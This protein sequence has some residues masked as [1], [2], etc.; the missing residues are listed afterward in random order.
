[1]GGGGGSNGLPAA[2]GET[3]GA[4]GIVVFR[5]APTLPATGGDPGAAL[6]IALTAL[7][8]GA[9]LAA[10]AGARRKRAAD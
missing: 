7:V 4:S 2:A 8:A 10:F 9:G 6:P 5:W 3:T 1:M